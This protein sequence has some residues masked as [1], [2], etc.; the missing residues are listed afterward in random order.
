M[1]QSSV[2]YVAVTFVIEDPELRWSIAAGEALSGES[3]FY[4]T[5][6]RTADGRDAILKVVIPGQNFPRQV[7]TIAPAEGRGYAALLA[8]DPFRERC[9]W[10]PSGR[11]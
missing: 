10:K 5:R 8:Q 4:V 11:R 2:R 6:A 1:L 3:A 7:R 9:C